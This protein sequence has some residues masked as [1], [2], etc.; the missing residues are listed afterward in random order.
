MLNGTHTSIHSL[1][2]PHCQYQYL[3][4]VDR[5]LCIYI[6]SHQQ[7]VALR[8][9][10]KPKFGWRRHPVAWHRRLETLIISGALCSEQKDALWSPCRN[11][12]E[13]QPTCGRGL[14][15]WEVRARR[16]T[17]RQKTFFFSFFKCASLQARC[18][19]SNACTVMCVTHLH[20]EAWLAEA[21]LVT[22]KRVPN[23]DHLFRPGE[24]RGGGGG[25]AR[26]FVSSDEREPRVRGFRRTLK[27]F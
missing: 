27:P 4:F 11:N 14:S 25:K 6:F 18:S 5:F 2:G 19:T 20:S 3:A 16:N 24:R 15:P 22:A 10:G 7:Y 13:N 9:P 8:S 21:R 17:F 26:P 23:I 12:T 1:V